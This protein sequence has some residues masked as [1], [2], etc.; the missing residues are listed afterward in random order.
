MTPRDREYEALRR[1]IEK[2]SEFEHSLYNFLYVSATAVLAW[3]ISS[4]NALI[5]L[6][7]YCII[8]PSFRIMLS[9]NSGILRIGAYMHVFYDEYF[10]EKRLHQICTLPK[11]KVVRYN[12]SY[13]TPFIFVSIL[14]TIL[15][16]MI[17]YENHVHKY[18]FNIIIIIL[19][20]LLLSTFVIYAFKQGNG[21]DIKQ[22]YI[23]AFKKIREADCNSADVQSETNE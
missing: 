22:Q 14:S 18:S 15:S 20:L 4:K 7:T 17:L 1:E 10:W 23:D 8:F 6:L 21:D 13:K 12:S 5:C 19:S 16:L 3:G 2:M 11:G 9:Y